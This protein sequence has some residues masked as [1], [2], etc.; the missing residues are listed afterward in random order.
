M[1]I[2]KLKIKVQQELT[3]LPPYWL[4]LE[5]P[6]LESTFIAN[7]YTE[8]PYAVEDY[9]RHSRVSGMVPEG[10]GGDKRHDWCYWERGGVGMGAWDERG[11]ANC[12]LFKMWSGATLTHGLDKMSHTGPSL[13]TLD[14]HW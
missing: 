1:S 13:K 10:G 4:R 3:N 6:F 14:K 12:V 9:E 11:E 7:N 8:K 2:H 5:I